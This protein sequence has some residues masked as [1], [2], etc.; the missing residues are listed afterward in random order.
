MSDEYYGVINSGS[1]KDGIDKYDKIIVM[2]C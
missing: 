1:L 2:Y